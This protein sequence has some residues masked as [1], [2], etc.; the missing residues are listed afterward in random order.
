M[1]ATLKIDTVL[2]RFAEA[3]GPSLPI[4]IEGN[5]TRWG[6]NGLLKP[7]TSVISAPSGL[8]EYK[9]EEMIVT[10]RAGTTVQELD[11]CL[12]D[13]R[14]R[15]SLPDR[16][17]TVGGA[18]AVGHNDL[19]KLGKGSVRDAVLQLRYVSAE[20]KVITCGGPVVKNVTG[21][22][23]HKLMVGSFGTLGFIAEVTL[24]TNPIP[25]RQLWIQTSMDPKIIFDTLQRPSAILWDGTTTW[26]HLEGHPPDVDAQYALLTKS[27]K[28]YESETGPS[29]PAHRWSIPPVDIFSLEKTL[30]GRFVA[31]IGV[32]T[33]WAEQPQEERKLDRATLTITE[34]MKKQFDPT[35][36]LNPGR[37]LGNWS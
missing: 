18:I 20:G 13:H 2:N 11:T 4:A 31:S 25:L 27:G 19:H 1:K 21:F 37:N 24:R 9:P 34:R 35:S 8:V 26:V 28:V 7:G 16:G 29:L 12:A 5:R 3:V 6:L 14:Q 22:N 30:M 15:T 36:R 33:V 32:G 10:V 23:L 17:G